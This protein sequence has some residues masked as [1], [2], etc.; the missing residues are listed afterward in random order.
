MRVGQYGV[1]GVSALYQTDA[2]QFFW[3]GDDSKIEILQHNSQFDATTRDAG[4]TPTTVIRSGLLLG[5][6]TSTGQLKHWDSAA[7]D[8]SQ[9]LF[10]VNREELDMLDPTGSA[11]D[12]FGP[13]VVRAPMKA[14]E[15][16]IKGAALIGHAD[17]YL[18]R[19]SLHG[20]GCVLDDDPQGWL[21]GMVRRNIIKT[22]T[23]AIVA[24]ENGA[25]FVV[26]GGA[27]VTLTLPAIKAG[28][29]YSFLVI[30][31]QNLV[32]ASAEGDNV[33]IINDA[34]ADSIAFSTSSQKIGAQLTVEAEYVNGTLKWIPSGA[35]GTQTTAT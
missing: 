1:P 12:R 20:M 26:N 10:S 21:T 5:R 23:G 13:S 4:S 18:A 34:S 8:G 28:L 31:D 17:E 11:V 27:A 25:L 22:A 14:K 7:T 29:R 16:L 2:R 33:I 9:H 32:V 19:Q 3:G 30:A 15:L 24:S 6:I 35:V